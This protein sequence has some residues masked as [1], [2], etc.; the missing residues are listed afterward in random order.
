[1]KA[2]SELR[3]AQTQGGVIRWANTYDKIVNVISL[4]RERAMRRQTIAKAA[5][6]PGERVLDVGCGTGTLAI[7]AAQAQPDL[8]V[9]AFD[10]AASMIERARAKAL[11]GGVQVRFEVGVIERIDAADGYYDV[12]L[13]SLMLHHLPPSLQRQG[14][15]EVLR[16]LR[17]GGR[18]VLV[19]F[20]GPGPLLHRLGAVFSK[21]HSHDPSGP[22]G[23]VHH[24]ESPDR[25]TRLLREVGFEAPETSRLSPRYLF[26]MVARKP[27]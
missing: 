13:S 11:E 10:P 12:V 16:V 9:H 7:A 24:H 19:D 1:M 2:G 18:L 8:E 14:L 20:A 22:H 25:V 23:A 27:G 3:D 15:R 26:C 21:R 5:L 4:G 17:P 6:A